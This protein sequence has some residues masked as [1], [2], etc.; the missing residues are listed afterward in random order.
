MKK[1]FS[2]IMLLFALSACNNADKSPHSNSEDPA[3]VQSP[4][5]AITDSTKIV[6]DSVV[7]PDTQRK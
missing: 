2:F 7:V 3:K 4:S 5:D 6:D 1:A